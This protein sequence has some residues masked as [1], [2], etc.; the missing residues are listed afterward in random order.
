MASPKA[1]SK[2]PQPMLSVTYC[3]LNVS[4]NVHCVGPEGGYKL[5]TRRV[6]SPLPRL[7]APP[8]SPVLSTEGGSDLQNVDDP[9]SPFGRLITFPF[10]ELCISLDGQF[11]LEEDSR[12]PN[13]SDSLRIGPKG[14]SSFPCLSDFSRSAN[15]MTGSLLP[16][17][18]RYLKEEYP[19]SRDFSIGGSDLPGSL[20]ALTLERSTGNK[21]EFMMVDKIWDQSANGYRI[22]ESPG[23]P[24]PFV[25]N[26]QFGKPNTEPKCSVNIKSKGLRAIVLQALEDDGNASAHSGEEDITIDL[27][28]LLNCV[29]QLK[30]RLALFTGFTPADS[31]KRAD[32]PGKHLEKLMEFLMPFQEI[33]PLEAPLNISFPL[34]A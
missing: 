3:P 22:V 33:Q 5:V 27:D 31:A 6:E 16:R 14:E 11:G 34:E 4:Q 7:H 29:P 18:H 15:P 32:K 30:D 2:V 9:G 20:Q 25:V 1:N 28:V 21:E 17:L 23:I 26:R 12:M 13:L 24:Y 10:N 19:A 8:G